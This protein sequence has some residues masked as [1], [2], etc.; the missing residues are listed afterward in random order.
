M[1]QRLNKGFKIPQRLKTRLR[2]RRRRECVTKKSL[3]TRVRCGDEKTRRRGTETPEQVCE[4][5]HR[6]NGAA[7]AAT[8]AAARPDNPLSVFFSRSAPYASPDCGEKHPKQPHP[9]PCRLLAPRGLGTGPELIAHKELAVGNKCLSQCSRVC[10]GVGATPC[11]ALWGAERC[12][13]VGL[14]VV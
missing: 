2:L 4:T 12:V 13:E 14:T 6:L 10:G 8:A 7:R 1:T 11:C 5:V 9:T 3:N